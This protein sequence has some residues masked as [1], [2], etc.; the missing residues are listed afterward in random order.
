MEEIMKKLMHAFTVMLAASALSC[1]AVRAATFRADVS[2]AP[3]QGGIGYFLFDLTNGTPTQLNAVTISNADT[4][5]LI[6]DLVVEGDVSGSLFPG[7]LTLLSSQFFNEARQISQFGTFLSF[8]FD[9]TSNFSAGSIPDSFSFFIIDTNFVPAPTSD[10]SGANALFFID[11]TG[12][13]AAPVVYTSDFAS[14]SIAQVPEP[15]C[16][17]AIITFGL[18]VFHLKRLQG[19]RRKNN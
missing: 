7:P 18:G 4:D 9:T 14:V 10:P 6:G 16:L 12:E 13:D 17:P 2:L 11:L 1:G 19:F 15:T 5:G 3:I 8:E